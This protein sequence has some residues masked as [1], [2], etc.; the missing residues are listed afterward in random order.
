LTNYSIKLIS[1]SKISSLGFGAGIGNYKQERFYDDN[2]SKCLNVNL[3]AGV[4]FIDSSPDYGNGKSE[5]LI[6][7]L[8]NSIRDKV[9]ISTKVSPSMLRNDDVKKSLELSL[10]RLRTDYVDLF[11]IHWSNPLIPFEETLEAINSL[12]ESGKIRMFGV[13]NLGIKEL[14]RIKNLSPIPITSL[15]SEYNLFDRSV[16]K[17]ILLFC[18]KNKML[19][20]AYSPLHR[21]KIIGNKDSYL[22]ILEISKK[23]NATPAQ[24]ALSWLMSI[25]NVVPIPNTTNIRRA[26]E[27]IQS[28]GLKITNTDLN[29]IGNNCSNEIVYLNPYDLEVENLDQN[30]SFNSIEDAKKNSLKLSPSPLELAEQINKGEFLKPIRVVKESNGKFLVKEGKL[31]YWSW[32]IAKGNQKIPSLIDESV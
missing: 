18:Q 14:E 8:T 21:G 22:R 7:K 23:Y 16:E 30:P 6:G 1:G 20:I 25:Q 29:D 17:E 4:N 11:Q 3:D 28:M 13:S 24:I 19:L 5:E 2:F 10:S 27:N 15:Q 9:F 26:L 32:L 12:Y 31:R